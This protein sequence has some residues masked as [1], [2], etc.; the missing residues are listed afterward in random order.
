MNAASQPPQP[1]GPDDPAGNS[2]AA[3]AEHTAATACG[4]EAPGTAGNPV[5]WRPARTASLTV[6]AEELAAAWTDPDRKGNVLLGIEFSS[7]VLALAG[8]PRRYVVLAE[9]DYLAHE[10][11]YERTL[12]RYEILAAELGGL[13]TEEE[14]EEARDRADARIDSEET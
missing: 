4:P 11:A 9:A 8:I 14:W 6:K 3:Y 2:Q 7:A 1:A 10:L 13:L 12:R 5:K